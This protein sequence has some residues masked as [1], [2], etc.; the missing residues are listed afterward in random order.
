MDG[1]APLYF[2][3][4]KGHTDVVSVLLTRNDLD[5]A[6]KWNGKTALDIAIL[7]GHQ[8]IAD[9]LRAAA[10][11]RRTNP[12]KKI[13]DSDKTS[14]M[15]AI[16]TDEHDL[17][18]EMLARADLDPAR[19]DDQGRTALFYAAR[20]NNHAAVRTL[21]QHPAINPNSLNL[22]EATPL[23]IAAQK[24]HL[25]SILAL[26]EHAEINVN[27]P[28]AESGATPLYVAAQHGYTEVVAALLTARRIDADQPTYLGASPLWIA[29]SRGHAAIVRLLADRPQINLDRTYDGDTASA[30]ASR[31][32]HADTVKALAVA[33]K[34]RRS[35]AAI[36][37]GLP[38]P[39]DGQPLDINRVTSRDEATRAIAAWRAY[40]IP[41]SDLQLMR[42]DLRGYTLHGRTELTPEQINTRYRNFFRHIDVANPNQRIH[43]AR[44]VQSLPE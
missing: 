12:N 35:T 20:Q 25:E 24:N 8:N 23:Y 43:F 39:F 38:I 41:E 2:A 4:F 19:A 36:E 3:A 15:A 33:H 32:N 7:N 44:L 5:L 13:D 28:L 26:L 16:E 11:E 42:A 9:L 1:T 31:N 40:D 6:K 17:I 37:R 22:Q 34:K 18:A 30:V 29:A 27:I 14:L 10:T 21:L